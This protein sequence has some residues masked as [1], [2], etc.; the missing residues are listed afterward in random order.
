MV[1]V[2]CEGIESV[3]M[4]YVLLVLEQLIFKGEVAFHLSKFLCPMGDAVNLHA[5]DTLPFNLLQT[6]LQEYFAEASES[7]WQICFLHVQVENE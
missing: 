1:E 7:S 3:K 4:K 2:N 5:S 6:K